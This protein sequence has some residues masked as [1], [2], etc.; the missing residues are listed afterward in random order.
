MTNFVSN[1]KYGYQ[2]LKFLIFHLLACKCRVNLVF[3]FVCLYRSR[4]PER[5]LRQ[6]TLEDKSMTHS[7]HLFSLE[8]LKKIEQYNQMN[9]TIKENKNQETIFKMDMISGDISLARYMLNGLSF[10]CLI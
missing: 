4:D 2:K 1:K 9:G 5:T 3:V 10:D 6:K 7:L 8:A